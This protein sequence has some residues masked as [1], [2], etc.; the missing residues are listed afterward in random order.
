MTATYRREALAS[1]LESLRGQASQRTAHA[2]YLERLL[3]AHRADGDG[4]AVLDAALPRGVSRSVAEAL[5]DDIGWIVWCEREPDVPGRAVF[6]GHYA[7]VRRL[8][9]QRHRARE[10]TLAGPSGAGMER[11]FPGV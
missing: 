2:E 4:N 5:D 7:D 1:R 6:P 8:A 3:T 11:L 9:A 10:A